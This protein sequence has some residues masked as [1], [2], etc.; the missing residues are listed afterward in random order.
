MKKI[1]CLIL[2][3]AVFILLSLPDSLFRK[4]MRIPPQSNVT[5]EQ[6]CK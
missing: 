2:L 4:V 5:V 1:V 6:G 3:F